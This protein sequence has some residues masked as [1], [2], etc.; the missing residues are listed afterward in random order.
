MKLPPSPPT[1][2][3]SDTSVSSIAVTLVSLVEG[4][5][6]CSSIPHTLLLLMLIAVLILLHTEPPV[7]NPSGAVYLVHLFIGGPSASRFAV[8]YIYCLLSLVVLTTPAPSSATCADYHD[9]ISCKNGNSNTKFISWWKWSVL[10]TVVILATVCPSL[11]VYAETINISMTRPTCYYFLACVLT[12]QYFA[13]T[14]TYGILVMA[15]LISRIISISHV[16]MK[17]EGSDKKQV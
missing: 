5:L 3:E 17:K 7:D 9:I 8:C 6:Q 14:V 12:N 10:M 15:G 13:F 4:P 1:L 11:Q 16:I 2:E